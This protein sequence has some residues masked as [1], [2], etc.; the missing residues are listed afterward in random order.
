VV[1]RDYTTTL[2]VKAEIAKNLVQHPNVR[3]SSFITT[4][5]LAMI[6]YEPQ[7]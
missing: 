6:L 2:D 3:S 7:A 4:P 1:L 5:P